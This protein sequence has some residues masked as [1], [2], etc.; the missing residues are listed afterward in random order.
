MDEMTQRNGAL[1]EQTTAS[2]QSLADQARELAAS[3]TFFKLDQEAEPRTA[4]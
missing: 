2:A 4:E 3:I 1:V